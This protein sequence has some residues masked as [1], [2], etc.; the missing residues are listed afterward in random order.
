MMIRLEI[1]EAA[2]LLI[3]LVVALRS[4]FLI[5]M[6]I[7]IILAVLVFI[8]LGLS[9]RQYLWQKEF[10]AGRFLTILVTLAI[11]YL[12]LLSSHIDRR[13]NQID[14]SLHDG[15]VLTEVAT[16]AILIGKNPY[17]INYRNAFSNVYNKPIEV[18]YDHYMYSPMTFLVNVPFKLILG[19]FFAFYDF[20]ITLVIFLFLSGLIGLLMVEKKILFLTIFL[21]NP[22]FLPLTFY[23]A[24]EVLILFFIIACLVAIFSKKFSIATVMLACATGT[25]LLALPFVPLYF[26]YLFL[27]SSPSKKTVQPNSSAGRLSIV[28][29][30]LLFILVNLIIYL[31]F[32][33]WSFSDLIEDVVL[34]HLRGG[35]GLHY[36]A[37]FLGVP[38]LLT[39]LGFLSVY[40]TFPFYG[41]QLVAALAF[42]YFAYRILQKSLNLITL[43]IL[44]V[45]FLSVILVFSRIIQISYIAYI[46]QF[47]LLASFQGQPYIS[48]K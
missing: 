14:Y 29:H 41:L 24:N 42:L 10:F 11:L 17:E 19:S 23:G 20:R 13:Q 32:A 31:P 7:L 8:F 16:E 40:S 36:I 25:K 37:G 9:F 5:S 28:S 43:N 6:P 1:L 27:L 33:I 47:L 35:E 39:N 44:F 30:L 2:L 38:Q 3:L 48:K 21:L 12:F 45:F 15:A 18:V 4:N 46:S 26:L 34:F 22:L